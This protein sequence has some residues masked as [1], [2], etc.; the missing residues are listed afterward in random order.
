MKHEAEAWQQLQATWL[1]DPAEKNYFMSSLGD[2]LRWRLWI[3]RA[4]LAVEIAAFVL[5]GVVVVALVLKGSFLE[6]AALGGVTLFCLGLSLWARRVPKMGN[7]A[8][9][10]GMIDLSISRTRSSLRLAYTSYVG[11]AMALAAVVLYSRAP[12]TEDAGFPGPLV[13]VA[14]FGIGTL[15]YHLYVRRR[16]RRFQDMRDALSR[17]E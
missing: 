6:G 15:T 14:L 8:S 9:L 13:T 1:S 5:L 11:V 4:W 10:M 12:L 17:N 2:S 7:K 16:L 3:S